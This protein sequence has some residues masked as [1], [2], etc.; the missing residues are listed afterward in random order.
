[1]PERTET[2]FNIFRNQA[3]MVCDLIFQ[4]FWVEKI[5]IHNKYRAV[6]RYLKS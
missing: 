3:E 4:L 5:Q 1:M 6:F 2:Y